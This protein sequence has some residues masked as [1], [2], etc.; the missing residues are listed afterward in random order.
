[1]TPLEENPPVQKKTRNR[2]M[3]GTAPQ[4]CSLRS[5]GAKPSVLDVVPDAPALKKLE[6]GGRGGRRK[7]EKHKWSFQA[8]KSITSENFDNE[9]EKEGQSDGTYPV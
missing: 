2:R 8:K 7:D 6:L 5:K 3:K 1:M 9:P 4:R